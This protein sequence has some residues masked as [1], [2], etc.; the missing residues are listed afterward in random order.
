[1]L[2]DK[3]KVITGL[4][5]YIF[6]WYL[7]YFFYSPV[8]TI[9]EIE[10]ALK[11]KNADLLDEY[12]DFNTLQHS[13]ITQLKTDLIFKATEKKQLNGIAD[14]QF[15]TNIT[16]TNKLVEDVIKLFLS[17]HGI[18]RLFDMSEIN[19]VTPSTIRARNF[20]SGLQSEFFIQNNSVEFKSFGTIE[21]NGLNEN[22]MQHKFILTFRYFRWFLTDIILDLQKVDDQ[23]VIE[24]ISHFNEVE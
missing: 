16:Y 3:K 5:V 9:N 6:C 14:P 2:K 17:K 4:L 23:K 20:I 12:I 21:I 11:Q 22:G 1:M 15:V 18:S 19:S 7:V 24:F 10:S 8:L 13:V